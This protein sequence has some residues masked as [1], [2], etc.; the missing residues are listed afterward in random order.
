MNST[1]LA[2]GIKKEQFIP[3][4]QLNL[5]LCQFKH[6]VLGNSLSFGKCSAS[7]I[8]SYSSCFFHKWCLDIWGINMTSWCRGERISICQQVLCFPLCLF[9]PYSTIFIMIQFLTSWLGSADVWQTKLYFGF[10][11]QTEP[12]LSGLDLALLCFA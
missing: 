2:S 6:D 7:Q 8:S 12:G 9:G 1:M 3:F 11:H 10:L 5:R 4:Y